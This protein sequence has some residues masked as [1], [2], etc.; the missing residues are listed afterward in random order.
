VFLLEQTLLSI[1]NK[2]KFY[3]ELKNI[4]CM[5]DL[6]GEFLD[7]FKIVKQGGYVV[8]IA[9]PI[10]GDEATR[11]F[12]PGPDGSGFHL[13]ACALCCIGCFLD[14]KAKTPKEEAAK[15]KIHYSAILMTPSGAELDVLTAHIESGLIVPVVDK[16]FPLK[17]AVEA[18]VYLES[19]RAKGKVVVKVRD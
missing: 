7:G 12:G 13:G 4:D 2:K 18:L 19:G 17:E 16:V 5:F 6:S 8:T 15:K 14:H 11:K 9:G 3:E 1:I 10:D